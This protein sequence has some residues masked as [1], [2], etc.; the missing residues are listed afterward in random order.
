MTGET[1]LKTCLLMSIFMIGMVC[2]IASARTI[3]VDDDGPSDF[4][5]IQ[6][7]IDDSNDGDTIIVKPG[8]Y[9]EYVRFYGKNITLTST[10]PYDF[11]I[12]A[13]TIIEYGVGFVGTEDPNCKLSGFRIKGWISGVDYG[14][15]PNGE[16]HT[17]ATISHCLLSGNRVYQGTVIMNCDGTISNC[18]VADNLPNSDHLGP[19]IQGCHGLIKNCT[20]ANNIRGVSVWGGVTT[21]ENCIIYG[22]GI[23]V[24]SGATVNINY[25]NVDLIWGDGSVN[26]ESESMNVYPFFVDEANGDYHLKSQGG[27]WNQSS[28]TWVKDAGTSPC[29]DAGNPHSPVGFEPFPNGGRINMGAYGGTPE[30]SKSYFGNPICETIVAGDINGDCKVNFLDFQLLALHWLGGKRYIPNNPPMVD[31]TR[32]QNGEV[33]DENYTIEIEADASDDDGVV[34][35]VEFFVDENK[36]GEDSNG[37]DGWK[38][39]WQDHPV[40]VYNLTAKATDDDEAQ[41]TS[42]P[43]EIT[44]DKGGPPGQP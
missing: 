43:I 32:P 13:N 22:S 26:W 12:V 15:Y 28:Q 41:T 17:H 35:K 6:G 10:K 18:V 16:I 29:I 24:G 25:S 37:A 23:H 9:L 14:I 3:Y 11:N 5:D 7:A 27:R 21:I 33:F 4:N 30:A 44:I 20:I 8:L 19:V 38:T 1:N 31:I 39:D 2:T 34:V 42:S 36:I 40:G